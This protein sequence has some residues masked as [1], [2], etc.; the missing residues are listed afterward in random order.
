MKPWR[1]AVCNVL[2][3]VLLCGILGIMEMAAMLPGLS[4]RSL[5]PVENA[6]GNSWEWE[7][8]VLL[9]SDTSGKTKY[10]K[11]HPTWFTYHFSGENG[12]K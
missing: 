9:T 12:R 8:P 1:S 10:G 2:D 3:V 6:A 11:T 7:K 4:G 5:T